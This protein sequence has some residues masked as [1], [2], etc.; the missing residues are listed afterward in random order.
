LA[1]VPAI[2]ARDIRSTAKQWLAGFIFLFPA[3][4]GLQFAETRVLIGEF[5]LLLRHAGFQSRVLAVQFLNGG[6]E[7]DRSGL[8]V[9]LEVRRAA[10]KGL[11]AAFHVVGKHFGEFLGDDVEV[12]LVL[13]AGRP[14]GTALFRG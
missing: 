4:C 10:G 8:R 13:D 9:H 7:V 14:E 1:L 12:A 11:A 6:G 5:L 3:E 2:T